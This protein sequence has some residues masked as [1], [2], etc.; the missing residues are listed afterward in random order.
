MNEND[1]CFVYVNPDGI[2]VSFSS[3]KDVCSKLEE[4]YTGLNKS[5][6][7][8]LEYEMEGACIE[9]LKLILDDWKI[10]NTNRLSEVTKLKDMAG[11]VNDTYSNLL[12][13]IK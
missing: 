2:Q 13:E 12:D 3:F 7:K 8:I 11:L 9:E 1:K 6:D 4:I 5:M 10:I